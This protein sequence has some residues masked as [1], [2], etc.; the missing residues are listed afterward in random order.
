LNDKNGTHC[1]P[2]NKSE[3]DFYCV[4]C[5]ETDKCYYFNP[6]YFDK[7]LTLRILP[8]KNNQEK[9]VKFA[10]DFLELDTVE[11]TRATPAMVKI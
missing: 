11:T 2:I 9:N 6:S 7:C 4:Y 10:N 8:C 1:K 5:P 3:I